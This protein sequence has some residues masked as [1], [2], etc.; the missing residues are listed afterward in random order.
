MRQIQFSPYVSIDSV[1]RA[2]SP[3]FWSLVLVILRPYWSRLASSRS[4]NRKCRLVK[5]TS[6][7]Q[8]WNVKSFTWV[9]CLHMSAPV[10]PFELLDYIGLHPRHVLAPVSLVQLCFF[11][12]ENSKLHCVLTVCIRGCFRQCVGIRPLRWRDD[13]HVGIFTYS[14]LLLHRL[15]IRAKVEPLSPPVRR[16]RN[17]LSL[18][19]VF[20]R[21]AAPVAIV[22]WRW[23]LGPYLNDVYTIFRI[24]DP[25]PPLSTFWQD[26]QD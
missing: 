9:E 2:P 4:V 18:Q 6:R 24:L 16:D 21:V 5:L 19:R 14:R 3:R 22:L 7:L 8:K 20:V 23:A 15:L 1:V 13:L 26:P 25:L 17:V 10:L 12:W 11:M